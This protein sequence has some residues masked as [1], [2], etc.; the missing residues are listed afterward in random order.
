MGTSSL[1]G[2]PL[3]KL[4]VER[5]QRSAKESQL[6]I[7]VLNRAAVAKNNMIKAKLG[8]TKSSIWM[9]VE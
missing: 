4:S 1:R 9:Y 7:A 5:D 6:G 2:S 3:W 8:S